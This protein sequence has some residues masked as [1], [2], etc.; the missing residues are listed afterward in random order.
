MKKFF[1][2]LT[3]IG[4]LAACKSGT[5]TTTTTEDTITNES[6]MADSVNKMVDTT[7]KM[8]DTTMKMDTGMRK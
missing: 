1:A 8:T 2:V 3:I 6:K 5:N 7:N 4:V